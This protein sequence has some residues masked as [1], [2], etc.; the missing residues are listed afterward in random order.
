MYM[1]Y[2]AITSD[3]LSKI[4]QFHKVIVL[5]GPRQV[6]KT[7]L[8]RHLIQQLQLKTLTINADESKYIRVLSSRDSRTMAEL[9]GNNELL[10]IDEAQRIP[11]IGINL[12]II[13][14]QFPQLKVITTGSSSFELANHISEPLTGRKWTWYLYPISQ[15]ELAQT[16]TAYE[17]K[18]QLPE[19]LVWGSYPEIVQLTG[20]QLKTDYLHELEN[21]YLYKDILTFLDL[22]GSQ[23]IKDLLRLLAFQIGHEVS[24]HELSTQLGFGIQTTKHYLDL[25]EKAFVIF[26]L[27]GFS[28]NLRKEVTKK[29]KYYFF[30]LGIRNVLID[31]LTPLDRR[32]DVGQLWENFCVVERLKYTHYTKQY[33]TGYFWRLYTG[34]EIDYVEDN[35]GVVH[36]F[37]C[38]WSTKKIVRPPASWTIEYPAATFQVITPDNYLAFVAGRP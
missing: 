8:A 33:S 32:D 22:P 35:Q 36:G 10:F 21:D 27:S 15:Y 14:D 13:I 29:K 9:I 34:A 23:R 28:R 6:G 17:L 30:D 7:T 3:I 25:L 2:R 26:Q 37:E 24:T 38:K 16:I 1:I 19:R 18:Q 4:R 31:R 11:D 20:Q 12:K 5:Y